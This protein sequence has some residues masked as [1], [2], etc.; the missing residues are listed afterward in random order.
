MLQDQ[1]IDKLSNGLWTVESRVTRRDG[2][3]VAQK[4]AQSIFGE[5][6]A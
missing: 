1:S 4:V 6:N 2:E 3:N 5:I